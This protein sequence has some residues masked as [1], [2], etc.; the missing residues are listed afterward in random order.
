VSNGR[1]KLPAEMRERAVDH[2]ERLARRLGATVVFSSR[3]VY[4]V[5][6]L[7][8]VVDYDTRRVTGPIITSAVEYL[9]HLHELGHL[10]SRS[11]SS[12]EVVDEG[13]AWAWA[14]KRAD[15]EIM[16]RMT[17]A[18]WALVGAAFTSYVKHYAVREA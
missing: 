16:S 5:A 4:N 2:V 11:K 10:A 17:A 6:Q 9:A 15:P 1:R 7:N 18:S 3:A 12:D 13:A 8:A 14:A